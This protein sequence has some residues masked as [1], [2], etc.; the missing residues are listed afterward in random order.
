[1]AES[2]AK[3]SSLTPRVFWL[4]LAKTLAFAFSFALPLLL[5]RRLSQTEFGLYKQVFLIVGTA[6]SILPLGFS[7]SAFYFLPRESKRKGGIIINIILFN[8]FV[9]GLALLT[10]VLRP[11]LIETIFN[12][13]A[14]MPY[15]PLIGLLILVWVMSYFLEI[16]ALANREVGLSTIFII[17]AQLTK[18]TLL[19]TAAI[20]FPTVRALLY[21]A[22]IQGALQTIVLLF[23]LRSRFG[24]FW[25]E[26]EWSMMRRQLGYTLPIGAAGLLYVVL[27]DL[28]NYFVSYRFGPAAFAIYAIGCFSLPL[29]GIIGE[30]VGPVMITRVSEL[31]NEGKTREIVQT[32][33]GAMRKL[34]AIYFPLY[35]LLL[36]VGREMIAFLFTEQ[37]LGSWPI[38]AINLTLLPF[39][40]LIADPIIRA[41]AEHRFFLLKVRAVTIVVLFTALLF[42]TKYFGLVGAISVMVGVS[43]VDRLVEAMK[44]W[45]IVNV[46]WRDISLIKD[47]GKVA[48]AAL[49]AGS[50]TAVVRVFV[51]GQR[52][53]LLLVVCGVAF[54]CFYA[55]FIWLL[56]VPSVEEREA[57]RSKFANVQR[58]I[59]SKR[60]LEPLT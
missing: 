7:M 32:L 46:T 43:I 12:S 14:L 21:A 44:A 38:F 58:V 29:V 53:F 41:H 52:P 57:I 15:A 13:P 2:T 54:G 11:S 8:F 25:R 50:L 19:L 22:I 39:L 36:V 4:I 3:S 51:M 5:V 60:T 49:A 48:V 24:Q 9:G 26:F 31:Q 1:M 6:A 34:S 16:S 56:G 37:Y 27:T 47:V 42:G 55:S 40:I 30:S 23:Y 10:L 18:T 45:R 17:G 35:A 59:L 33:A 20:N 28:H